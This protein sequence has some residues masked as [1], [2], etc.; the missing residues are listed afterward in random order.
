LASDQSD[1]LA[2]AYARLSALR[3]NIPKG[4]M[5]DG[6]YLRE[7]HEALKHLEELGFDVAEFKVP[8]RLVRYTFLFVGGSMVERALLLSKLDAVLAYFELVT[9]KAPASIGFKR[10]SGG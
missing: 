8:D 3:E 9:Q 2:R 7:Y 6:L 5:V 4:N 1:K 10:P